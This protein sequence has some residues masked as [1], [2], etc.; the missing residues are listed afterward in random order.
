MIARVFSRHFFLLVLI[1]LQQREGWHM[2]NNLIAKAF[3]I[4]YLTIHSLFE[5]S[6]CALSNDTKLTQFDW[7][8]PN[9]SNDLTMPSKFG[10]IGFNFG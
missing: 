10:L 6:G 3:K 9:I 2:L 8:L 7:H 4:F 5:S 1:S